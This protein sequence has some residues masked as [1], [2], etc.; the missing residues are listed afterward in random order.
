MSDYSADDPLQGATATTALT[1][2]WAAT[3]HTEA[4]RMPIGKVYAPVG[5][6]GVTAAVQRPGAA[7][8]YALEVV[9]Y[10]DLEELADDLLARS[11]S[12]CWTMVGGAPRLDLDLTLL[13][14]RLGSN[15]TDMA[16]TTYVIDVDG[17]APRPGQNL[18]RPKDFGLSAISSFRARLIKAGIYSLAKAKLV[19]LATASSGFPT[20][21]RGEPANGRAWFR[22]IFQTSTPL[23]LGQQKVFT[24]TLGKLPG[25]QS[26]DP[27]KTT[28]LDTDICSL[29]GNIFV[30]PVQG[31]ADRIETRVRTFPT[32][33]EAADAV[34]VDQLAKEL[35][36]VD[37]APPIEPEAPRKPKGERV[38]QAPP[39]KRE[40]LLSALL[41]ALPNEA[42]FGREK[43]VGVAHACFGAAD[44]ADWAYDVWSEWSLR[45]PGGDDPLDRERTWNTLPVGDN[46]IGYLVGW[47]RNVGTPEALAAVQ[48]IELALFEPIE[49]NGDGDG[50]G[51]GDG[52]EDGDEDF[53]DL[54][55]RRMPAIDP[56]AF[57]GVLRPIVEATT[58]RSEATKIGVAVQM[59]ARTSLTMRPFYNPMGDIKLPF[60]IYG[61]QVGPT[62]LGRKGTSATV[63]NNFLAPAISRL[64]LIM[65]ARLAFTD[66]DEQARQDGENK[67]A[68]ATR[69]LL[70]V[71]SV[72][73]AERARTEATLDKL[74]DEGAETSR[75]ILE[76]RK[77][78][79][80]K[81]RSP[82]T[83]REYENLITAAEAKNADIVDRTK[84]SETYLANVAAVLKDHPAAIAAAAAAL[85]IA[86]EA[87]GKLPER[88]SPPEPWVALFASLTSGVV[89]THGLS[90]GEGVIELIRDPGTRQGQ[91]GPIHDPGVEAKI[92]FVD[93]EEFGGALTVMARPGSTLSTVMR[94]AFDCK[95]L[96]LP[97]KTSPTHCEEPYVAL[98]AGVTP[99]ELMGKLFDKRDAAANADNGFA[100]RFLYFW[101]KRERI[102][103]D[104]Q[105]TPD[106]DK[107]MD[108]IAANI[109]NVYEALKPMSAFMAAPIDFSPEARAKYKPQYRKLAN[110][111]AAGA[112]AAKLTQRLTVYWRKLA[113]ILAVMNGEPE[114]SVGALDAARV[115]IDYAGETVD[116]IAATA[117]ER[118]RTRV[119]ID[120]GETVLKTLK[121]MEADK[122][123]V[124]ARA[125]Q[126]RA[127]L[128]KKEFEA[129]ILSLTRLG[130]SPITVSTEM[131]T[132]GSK[133]R[134]AKT[135]ITLHVVE[136]NTD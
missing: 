45:W 27:G 39:E 21:S 5:K 127:H 76:R 17:M 55:A 4:D 129:A 80:A 15:F 19:F 10:R 14:R 32:L 101:T 132:T 36:F 49:G 8:T 123:P 84:E 94:T 119:L 59:M 16:T 58:A 28:C 118:K 126:Q 3:S 22:A 62:A 61:L 79:K 75:E 31:I 44:G 35:K 135:M 29:A 103:P 133:A 116:A 71:E 89:V 50:D 56:R 65:A 24:A 109:L 46:G 23:T 96:D 99:A 63:A 73:D 131:A 54:L 11:Q 115:W 105:A 40:A 41:N 33:L 108:G 128:D 30:A 86:R 34:D 77:Y 13:H 107:M 2:T 38:M 102:E 134:R 117:A 47:A 81:I 90:T 130:P 100:N 125:V 60:N 53:D 110:H 7:N 70:W 114:I 67:V 72:D 1:V 52:N 83:Q 25:F 42:E 78:L 26:T 87:L 111:R 121:V 18:S 43:W 92:L 74:R 66:E 106:L 113:A 120:D 20:N 136:D 64:A 69:N 57:Y 9:A 95:P 12:G 97:S 104:P 124:S 91:R 6:W 48:S 82:R 88:G 68:E 112:N 51:K 98:S 93:L 85:A 122:A 37:G